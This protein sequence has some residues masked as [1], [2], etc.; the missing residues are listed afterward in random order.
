MNQY[1]AAIAS[2]VLLCTSL[3]V[4]ET[5]KIVVLG[6]PPDHIAELQ[7]VSPDARIVSADESS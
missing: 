5:R 4:P 2:W 7:N 3:A 1:I 6:M